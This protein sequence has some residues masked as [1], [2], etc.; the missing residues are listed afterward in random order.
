M[1]T[2]WL[3]GIAAI[4]SALAQILEARWGSGR[5]VRTL[6]EHLVKRADRVDAHLGLPP[7]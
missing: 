4:V 6:L 2:S 7:L 5:D 1:D 3:I